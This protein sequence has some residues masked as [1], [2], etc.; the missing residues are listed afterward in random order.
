[1]SI[2]KGVIPMGIKNSLQ[3]AKYECRFMLYGACGPMIQHL[4]DSGFRNFDSGTLESIVG[5]SSMLPDIAAASGIVLGSYRAGKAIDGKWPKM[6][7]GSVQ[8]MTYAA[9]IAATI[10]AGASMDNN[11]SSEGI[12][13]ATT[14]GNQFMGTVEYFTKGEMAP[15][16][17]TSLYGG[18]ATGTA[19]W[20]KNVGSSLIKMFAGKP[21]PTDN[22]QEN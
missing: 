9:L 22:Y 1:M 4:Y 21:G 18:L 7:R 17:Y 3:N 20:I 8:T 15:L 5:K 12:N 19:R 13:Y 6:L 2:T 10:Y 11:A 16:L 14:M